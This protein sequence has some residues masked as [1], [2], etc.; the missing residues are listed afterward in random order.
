MMFFNIPNSVQYTPYK[1]GVQ[2]VRTWVYIQVYAKANSC[3][4][5]KAYSVQVYALSDKLNGQGGH[6][7]RPIE[8]S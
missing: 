2:F 8:I 4:E 6:S 3:L 7:V 1:G 5:V